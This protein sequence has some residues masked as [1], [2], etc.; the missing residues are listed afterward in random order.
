VEIKERSM[1]HVNIKHFPNELTN[2]EKSSLAESITTLVAEHFGTS[3]GAVSIALEPVTKDDW[4]DTVV[5]PRSP[6]AENC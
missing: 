5:Q 1:P 4:D 2:D 6:A 3:E